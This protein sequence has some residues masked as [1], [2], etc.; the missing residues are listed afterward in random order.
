M[1]NPPGTLYLVP[2]PIGHPDDIT[3]RAVAVLE[4]VHL[5]AAEDTR[6]A[7]ALLR[8][9]GLHKPLISYF[10]HNERDR[11]S[12]ILGRLLAGEDVAVVS[13]AGTPMLSDPGF[14]IVREAVK[15]GIRVVGLPG[16]SAAI[17]ALL[18]AGLP[19][20][21][22]LFIGFL[23]RVAGPR[24]SRVAALRR[25]PH[26]L[27]FYEAPRRA[28]E[29]LACLEKVLGDRQAALAFELT[30]EREEI[31]RGP[32]SAIRARLEEREWMGEMTLVV[33]GAS[34][35]E[36]DYTVAD[37]LIGELLRRGIRPRDVRD[38]VSST[39]ELPKGD[40]YQRVLAAAK[41]GGHGEGE[42][43]R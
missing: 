28:V 14:L 34:E 35:A 31:L 9:L 5:V 6:N 4:R 20:S 1:T 10:D 29:T 3:R 8:P 12:Q 22:F 18:V 7:I 36:Q 27:V 30:K 39:L 11:T 2:T 21:S 38:I 15:N 43:A 16:P 32:L 25:E 41:G 37:K 40:V 13:D 24:E 23:P 42:P 26:T 33:E 17:A 19:T